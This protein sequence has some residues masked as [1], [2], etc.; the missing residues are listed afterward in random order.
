MIKNF[1]TSFQKR[2]RCTFLGVGPMSKNCVDVSIEIANRYNFPFFLIA[3][4]RQIDS[5]KFGGGYVN[6]WTT[7]EFSKYVLERNKKGNI[8]LCRDHGG[9]WQNSKEVERNLN[10]KEAMDSAKQSYEDDI[11]S[12]FKILHLDPSI[13]IHQK[14]T[15]KETVN[16]LLELYEYCWFKA[17]DLGKEIAF[18]IGTEEQSGGT[19][20]L[21]D[22]EFAIERIK[23]FCKCENIPEPTFVVIQCGTRVLETTNVGSFDIPLRVSKEIPAEIQIARAIEL[24]KKNNIMMKAHNTDYL[25]NESLDWHPKLGIH[26]ANVAPEFGVAETKSFL[27]ILKDNNLNLLFEEFVNLSL[28]SEKWKKWLKPN[29]QINDLEKAIIAGHYIF[30]TNNF[31]EL[32]NKAKYELN[33]KE[34]NLDKVLKNDIKNSILRYLKNFKLT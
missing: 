22:L 5:E 32:K 17:K 10:L 16:R 15:A 33:K 18:E 21:E 31:K 30:S 24:C 2:E 27:N 6:N 13:D 7:E 26:A 12:G 34:I 28:N 25:S 9:P 19:N 23:N 14:L 3:S 8:M 29:S 11:K 20:E 4:R 1:L